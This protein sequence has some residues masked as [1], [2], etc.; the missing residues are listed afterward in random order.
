MD[1]LSLLGT[2]IVITQLQQTVSHYTLLLA[3]LTPQH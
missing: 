2:E 3:L 1:G